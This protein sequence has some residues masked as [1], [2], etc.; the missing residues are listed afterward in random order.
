M[1]WPGRPIKRISGG[2][3]FAFGRPIVLVEVVCTSGRRVS[4][5]PTRW[6]SHG[7]TPSPA[8]HRKQ[9]DSTGIDTFVDSVEIV[10][11]V[12]IIVG[13]FTRLAAV[14]LIINFI[15]TIIVTKTPVLLRQRYW[16]LTPE[17][18]SYNGFWRFLHAWR[19]DYTMLLGS[20]H[21]LLVG[22]R[23]DQL[24]LTYRISSQR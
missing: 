17:L 6:Q 18:T 4:S 20:I 15:V 14:P 24:M 11:G 19:T 13:L 3:D 7:G 5:C 12:L 2:D 9:R 21:L 1:S 22:E 23:P 8:Y 10:A 16:I